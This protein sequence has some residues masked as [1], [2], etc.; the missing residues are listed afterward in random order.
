VF[1]AGWLAGSGAIPY[2]LL[3][4]IANAVQAGLTYQL[5]RRGV[6]QVP[7]QGF[8][9]FLRFYAGGLW[10][11]AFVLF[12]LPLLV[13]VV[14]VPVLLAQAILL[15]AIPLLNYQLQRFWTFRQRRAAPPI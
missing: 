11:L 7:G 13:E 12:G 15:V 3:A 10:A 5:Y 8:R 4:L 1:A 9:G 2:P 6:W 14:G